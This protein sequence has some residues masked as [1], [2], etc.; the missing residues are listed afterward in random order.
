MPLTGGTPIPAPDVAGP[1]LVLL[2]L[3]ST[4]K[5]SQDRSR[6]LAFVSGFAHA[7]RIPVRWVCLGYRPEDQGPNRFI[8]GLGS[9]DVA[10]VCT[11]LQSQGTTHLLATERLADG[12]VRTLQVTRPGLRIA[13]TEQEFGTVAAASKWMGLHASWDEHDGAYLAD[14]V[15][16]HYGCE[17]LNPLAQ[18][19]RPFV[20]VI[21]GPECVYRRPLSA[22]P[23]FAALAAK[24][25]DLPGH[26]SFCWPGP[27]QRPYATP[28][29]DLAIRQVRAAS[30]QLPEPRRTG[31]YVVDGIPL[32]FHLRAFVEALL[33][34]DLPP[35]A[36]LFSTR[37]DE[38]LRMAPV[39]EEVLPRLA[40]AGHAIHVHNMGVENFSPAENARLNKGINL[41][42]VES[43]VAHIRRWE[44]DWP[45][46]FAFF[47]YGGFGFIT[48]TPWTTLDDLDANANAMDRL[49]LPYGSLFLTSRMILLPGRPITLLAEQDGLTTERFED[50]AVARTAPGGCLVS[51]DA[52]EVPW[53]FADLAVGN[54]YST[55]IRIVPPAADALEDDP[56]VP[57]LRGVVAQKHA[58]EMG[59]SGAF[60]RLLLRAARERPAARS[61][62]EFL[63]RAARL[64][65][66]A[67]PSPELPAFPPGPWPEPVAR[68][69]RGFDASPTRP[70]RGF[71]VERV[72]ADAAEGGLQIT[73]GLRRER[74][75]LLLLVRAAGA[76]E[77]PYLQA[78]RLD[79]CYRRE[80]PIDT[81]EKADIARAVLDALDRS[82]PQ[83]AGSQDSM[84]GLV[85][86]S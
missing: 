26:C 8:V 39:I 85:M 25:P 71:V 57:E 38:V 66:A 64:A 19:I 1:R 41:A 28:A 53:R 55:L 59:R 30:R 20:H 42:D 84:A 12:L 2:E 74:E 35:S 68:V 81:P 65:P 48:F 11:V 62:M 86:K 31:E 33:A 15:E 32:F 29:V 56:Q 76:F 46:A 23:V 21:A 37:V 82:L 73:I 17:L 69:L 45:R 6:N 58:H 54:L 77:H 60:F 49:G 47:R 79:L 80:T 5:F 3:L 52:R 16:P 51:A 63:S 72:R 34:E 14:V 75:E 40:Q 9:E 22:N 70:L 18:Q 13:T 36:F 83:N 44:R 7:R 27:S 50:D 78:R 10:R 67:P 24:R 4:D 61:P 43:A